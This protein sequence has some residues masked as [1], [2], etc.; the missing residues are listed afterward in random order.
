MGCASSIVGPGPCEEDPALL[1]MPSADEL[2]THR[3]IDNMDFYSDADTAEEPSAMSASMSMKARCMLFRFSHGI[4]D[5][6]MQYD[7]EVRASIPV[8]TYEDFDF[9][10]DWQ[11][12]TRD[13]LNGEKPLPIEEKLILRPSGEGASTA[14]SAKVD[15]ARTEAAFVRSQRSANGASMYLCQSPTIAANSVPTSPHAGLASPTN[16]ACGA[17]GTSL[18]TMQASTNSI[19]DLLNPPTRTTS[20]ATY[21]LEQ[22]RAQNA[23]KYVMSPATESNLV[24]YENDTVLQLPTSSVAATEMAKQRPQSPPTVEPVSPS[25]ALLPGQVEGV[26]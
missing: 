22:R 5:D 17:Q 21:T 9:V 7:F 18:E 1:P 16:A 19:S 8:Y 4:N 3:E 15:T 10:R 14:S 25:D 2:R 6:V 20:H 11:V 24:P 12:E 26:A 23:A 13:A